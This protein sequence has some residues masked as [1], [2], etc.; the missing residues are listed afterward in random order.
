MDYEIYSKLLNIIILLSQ[1]LFRCTP[2][3]FL[4]PAHLLL[5]EAPIK[6]LDRNFV[7]IHFEFT[8]DLALKVVM[9][10][11]ELVDVIIWVEDEVQ[12]RFDVVAFFGPVVI[13]GGWGLVTN[14]VDAYFLAVDANSLPVVWVLWV[15]LARVFEHHGWFK[16]GVIVAVL[17]V[18]HVNSHHPEAG[19]VHVNVVH[20]SHWTW[21]DLVHAININYLSV[22]LENKLQLSVHYQVLGSRCQNRSV[23]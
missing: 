13:V 5:Q 14:T 15:G 12:V 11:R 3:D 6:S 19:T 21:N 22:E 8:L 10:Q 23:S 17:V 4:G 18:G 7:R 2:L 20:A 9:D 16:E 1:F